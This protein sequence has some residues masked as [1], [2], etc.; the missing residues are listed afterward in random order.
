MHKPVYE[1]TSPFPRTDFSCGLCDSYAKSRVAVRYRDPDGEFSDLSVEVLGDETLARQFDAVHLRLCATSAVE[2]CKPTP[3]CSSKISVRAERLVTHDSYG[4]IW[5]PGFCILAR[6]NDGRSP[7]S[8]NH[9]ATFARVVRTI[10][11]EDGDLVIRRD[12]VPQV[13]EH[14]GVTDVACRNL[15]A[16]SSQRI[17]ETKP[18]VPP[19]GR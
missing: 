19:I 15:D 18:F 7:P 14:G 4:C 13:T 2:P 17:C 11:G 5:L 8:R 16:T 1:C 10:D 9:I 3:K 6:R 12:L